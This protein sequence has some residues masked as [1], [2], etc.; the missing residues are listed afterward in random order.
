MLWAFRFCLTSARSNFSSSFLC[1]V[2]A[3]IFLMCASNYLRIGPLTLHDSANASRI[4]SFFLTRS[5]SVTRYCNY[6]ICRSCYLIFFSCSLSFTRHVVIASF[7][8]VSY[9]VKLLTLSCN[10]AFS[11]CKICISSSFSAG[12]IWAASAN[13]AAFYGIGSYDK[14]ASS[15]FFTSCYVS[16][17]YVV[18]CRKWPLIRASTSNFISSMANQRPAMAYGW[19]ST[20]TCIHRIISSTRSRTSRCYVGSSS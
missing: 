5:F 8:T 12:S 16:P 3:T 9:D 6:S 13:F 14:N 17:V 19:V 4:V 1:R 10:E 11:T 2:R 20:L 7:A 18:V 15:I